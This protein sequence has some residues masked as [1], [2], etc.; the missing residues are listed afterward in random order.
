[1]H[2][3]KN[4]L[5]KEVHSF[6]FHGGFNDLIDYLNTLATVENEVPVLG[7]S[8]SS[9]YAELSIIKSNMKTRKSIS[10]YIKKWLKEKNIQRQ[11]YIYKRANIERDHWRKLV[12]GTTHEPE[13]RTLYKLAIAFELTI[14]ETNEFLLNFNRAFS[15]G[16]NMTDQIV[17]Y[18][19]SNRIY[20]PAVIDEMLHEFGEEALFSDDN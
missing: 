11:S 6:I 1:M 8:L 16:S 13:L 2:S 7:H 19:I 4:G 17:S 10:Y 12:S 14:E 18:F 20:E 3:L 5:K 15:S 9:I